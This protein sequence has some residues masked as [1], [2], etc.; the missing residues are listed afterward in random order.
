MIQ[1]EADPSLPSH[2]AAGKLPHQYSRIIAWISPEASELS[3]SFS[4]ACG[5][6]NYCSLNG[7]S[8]SKSQNKYLHLR[9]NYE[10]KMIQAHSTPSSTLFPSQPG[11]SALPDK[12]QSVA[13]TLECG[14]SA[15]RCHS[16]RGNRLWH[17]C[18]PVSSQDQISANER[19]STSTLSLS[20]Q[21]LCGSPAQG[22][23][24]SVLLQSFWMGTQAAA[25]HF[26]ELLFQS[27]TLFYSL[28][29]SCCNC[30]KCQHRLTD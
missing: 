23:G 18:M 20:L 1:R 25:G 2:T 12:A 6:R 9:C 22:A 7:Q 8:F 21:S 24:G 19:L 3:E 27:S 15:W 14:V 4:L 29:D 10:I 16:G 11:C 5:Y 17:V 30:R 13:R 28:P 26:L